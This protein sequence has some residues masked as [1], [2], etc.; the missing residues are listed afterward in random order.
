M[1]EQSLRVLTGTRAGVLYVKGSVEGQ[2]TLL[3]LP[4]PHDAN[5]NS[6]I[7]DVTLRKKT[8]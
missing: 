5:A 4:S 1:V 7:L 2:H 6:N 3:R 8:A